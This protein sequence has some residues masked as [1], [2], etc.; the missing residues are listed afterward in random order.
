MQNEL[1]TAIFGN[2]PLE[3]RQPGAA[4]N[5]LAPVQV[6][7]EPGLILIRDTPQPHTRETV[8]AFAAALAS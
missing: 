7:L 3:R 4:L 8:E 5:R 6:E 2:E 1:T